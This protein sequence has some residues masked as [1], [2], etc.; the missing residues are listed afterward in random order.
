MPDVDCVPFPRIAAVAG[1]PLVPDI[2]TVAIAV[3]PAFVGVHNV[4]SVTGVAFIPAVA[5][6]PAFACIPAIDYKLV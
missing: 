1:V 5:G 4:V 3:L 2:L 6:N